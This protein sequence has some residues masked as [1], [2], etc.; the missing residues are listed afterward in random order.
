M[1]DRYSMGRGGPRPKVTINPPG[2]R[3]T[4]SQASVWIAG[5]Q[6]WAEVLT[7]FCEWTIPGR[8]DL[9]LPASTHLRPPRLRGCLGVVHD[10]ESFDSANGCLGRGFI[11]CFPEYNVCA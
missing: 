8:G 5:S 7:P 9:G 2:I 6:W 11:G 4:K 3:G 1:L 10:A